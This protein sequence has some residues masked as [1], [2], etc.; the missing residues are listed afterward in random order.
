[1]NSGEKEFVHKYLCIPGSN[2]NLENRGVSREKILAGSGNGTR[3]ILVEGER[4]HHCAI[5][6]TPV[7]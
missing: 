7:T 6:A 4:S 5:P 2:W 1:M 3:N